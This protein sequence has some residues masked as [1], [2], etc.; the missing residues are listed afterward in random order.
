MSL[1]RRL[2]MSR[3]IREFASRMEF[4]EAGESFADKVE[5]TLLGLEVDRIYLE[6]GIIAIHGLELDGRTASVADQI[7]SGPEALSREMVAA[8]RAECGLSEDERKNS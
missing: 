2:E 5:S 4:A 8:V 1:G 6:W 3:R 7:E